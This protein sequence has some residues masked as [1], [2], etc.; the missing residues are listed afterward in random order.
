[1]NLDMFGNQVGFNYK[2]KPKY[3]TCIGASCSLLIFILMIFYAVKLVKI[4]VMLAEVPIIHE[5]HRKGFF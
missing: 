4:S 3:D 1:M 2:G 5:Q